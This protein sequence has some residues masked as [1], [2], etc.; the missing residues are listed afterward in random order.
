M[1]Q[2]PN[3]VG[4]LE[5]WY[6]S[7]DLTSFYIYRYKTAFCPY[8]Q[9]KHDWAKCMYAHRVQDYRYLGYQACS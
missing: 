4:R 8:L 3:S 6:A 7:M 9:E 5:D 2:T 1:P